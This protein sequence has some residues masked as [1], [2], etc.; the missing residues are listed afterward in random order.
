VAVAEAIVIKLA[1]L[2]ITV[3]NFTKILTNNVVADTRSQ[4]EREAFFLTLLREKCLN[5]LLPEYSLDS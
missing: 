2:S 4:T 5:N 3:R 1:L